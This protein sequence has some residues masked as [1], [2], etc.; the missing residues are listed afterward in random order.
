MSAGQP[1]QV[2]RARLGPYAVLGENRSLALLL[3]AHALSALIDWLYVVALFILSYR[4]THSATAVALLTVTRLLPYALL[5]PVAGAI[6]DRVSAEKVMVGATVGRAVVMLGLL[7][8]HSSATLPLAYPLV[9]AAALM[10]SLFR[11]ALLASVPHVATEE[12]V[13]AA[14][15]IMGQVDMA[16]FGA[17]PALAGFI[18][19]AGT[20]QAVLLT[21]FVGLLLAAGAVAVAR[22]PVQEA[23]ASH[24]SWRA[25]TAAGL[26]F[27]L[28][29]DDR[30]LLAIAVSW[31]GL[32][33]FGG[34]YWALSVEL[35]PR[36]F[37]LGTQGIGFLNGAYAVGGLLGGLL[38]APLI[39]RRSA[40]SLFLA[41]AGA[42]SLAEILF[43]LSPAG[44][45]PF[46]FWFLTGFADAFAKITAITIIQAAT[47]GALLGRVFGAFESLIIGSMLVGALVVSPAID[48]LGARTACAAVAAFGLLLLVASVPVL[49]RRETVVDVRVL[50]LQVPALHQLPVD[51]L[52]TV[53]QRLQLVRFETGQTIIRE[54]DTGDLLYVIKR[55][56]VD[57]VYGPE[58]RHEVR[59][60]TL[61]RG[62]YF[63]ETALIRDI[64]RT[65]TCRALD[66]VEVYTL[67]R[68]EFHTLRQASE[69]FDRMVRARSDGRLLA[70]QNR[71]LFP[72]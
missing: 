71:L 31:A 72:V 48:L 12:Q 5:V 15:S 13:L 47:P 26:Q 41:G 14:N 11:P 35:A 40:V 36:A 37:H 54:G 30:T 28:H 56:T 45:L 58:G 29:G 51:L 25:H 42:S 1:V 49:R 38:I 52:D 22:I 53:V 50:L 3:S 44:V 32:T 24:E 7:A 19:V 46:T 33:F 17:G 16:S 43:G 61:S 10:S 59:L 62:D 2:K 60:S 66:V 23:E 68:S 57:V 69:D 34:A 55:G 64:P 27:L 70:N 8:V 9:F 21:A 6:S 39:S 67:S 20:T 18:L 63:G 4:L 65:A